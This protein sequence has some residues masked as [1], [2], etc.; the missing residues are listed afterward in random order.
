[1][2]PKN[3]EEQLNELMKKPDEDKTEVAAI[4]INQNVDGSNVTNKNTNIIGDNNILI[5]GDDDISVV[6]ELVDSFLEL[7]SYAKKD[8]KI[9]SECLR[10]F[11]E[12]FNLTT[13]KLVTENDYDKIIRWFERQE[14]GLLKTLVKTWRQELFKDID[15]FVEKIQCPVESEN[16]I[17]IIF[18]KQ[19]SLDDL[20]ICDL[21]T[22]HDIMRRRSEFKPCSELV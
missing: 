17:Y 7:N 19:R 12:R 9:L 3:L 22:F 15:N 18:G 8:N 20:D 11:I 2:A 4:S 13:L 21:K 14:V 6:K 10:E 5:N 16:M 1:M